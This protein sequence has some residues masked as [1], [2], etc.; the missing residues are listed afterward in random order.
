ME[1]SIVTIRNE[2]ISDKDGYLIQDKPYFFFILTDRACL[3][4]NSA[5][6]VLRLCECWIRILCQYVL[7]PFSTSHSNHYFLIVGLECL[8]WIGI[9]L[10][11]LLYR[12]PYPHT[13]FN[14]SFLPRPSKFSF[15]ICQTL[16]Q[17][18]QSHGS[19]EAFRKSSCPLINGV[20][21]SNY[22]FMV[23]TETSKRESVQ[24]IMFALVRTFQPQ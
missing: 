9:L 17:R 23:C 24:F 10:I 22:C 6:T 2:T 13:I 21:K 19:K 20:K 8:Y 1:F 15:T 7:L 3:H 12:L 4:W 18:T 11:F 14:R 5:V 16:A